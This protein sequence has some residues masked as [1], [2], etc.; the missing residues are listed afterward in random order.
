MSKGYGRDLIWC[1]I[2]ESVNETFC[3]IVCSNL[4]KAL[5]PVLE[6]KLKQQLLKYYRCLITDASLDCPFEAY[7]RAQ[8]N[9]NLINLKVKNLLS[10][11]VT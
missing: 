4:R 11:P 7:P 5:S 2:A 9:Y 1:P 3:S 6:D 10:F 8:T